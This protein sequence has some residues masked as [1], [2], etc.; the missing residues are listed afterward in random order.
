MRNALLTVI[1]AIPADT[2]I[3]EGTTSAAASDAET[4]TICFSSR[5]DLSSTG[6]NGAKAQIGEMK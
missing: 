6:R 5:N 1:F 4:I 3:A 2:R